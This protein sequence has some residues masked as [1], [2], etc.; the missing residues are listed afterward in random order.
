[1][2]L[3]WKRSSILGLAAAA[4]MPMSAFADSIDPALVIRDIDKHETITIRKTVT[5]SEGAGA[6]PVDI[7]FLA[8]TTGSMS[9]QIAAVQAAASSI[10]ASVSPGDVEFGV[11]GYRDLGDSYIVQDNISGTQHT[12]A[13]NG[14]VGTLSADRS[15]GGTVDTA[16][17]AWSAGGGG[18]SPEAQLIALTDVASQTA[19]RAGSERLVVWF[20]DQPG[21]E[22]PEAGYP[23]RAATIAALNAAGVSVLAID[24][25]F[26]DST[27]QASGIAA[28]TG[29]DFFSGIDETTLVDTINAAIDA[30]VNSYSEVRLEAVGVSGLTVSFSPASILGAFDRSIER[31]FEFDMTITGDT[32][33]LHAFT[34]NALVDGGVIARERD[35][36]NVPEPATVALLGLGFVA[37]G[38]ARRRRNTTSIA[39]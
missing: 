11:G 24:V 13:A 22:A 27:G 2:K 9:G 23:S 25:G 14:F 1:M 3:E 39:A 38:A 15:A 32:S 18:D 10:L 4:V 17:Q 36:I 31:T 5:V 19:W 30:A 37:V 26:L 33:G 28:G 34:V 20:G 8:D 29:G 35:L 12:D 6:A 7:Y 16:I 21:H